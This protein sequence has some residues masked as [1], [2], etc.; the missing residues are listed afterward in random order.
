MNKRLVALASA[1]VLA[2]TAAGA[3]S[4]VNNIGATATT[5]SP[6]GA[7]QVVTVAAKAMPTAT[8]PVAAAPAVAGA[9]TTTR[10]EVLA[11]DKL[12]PLNLSTMRLWNWSGV[13]HASEWDNTESPIPWRFNHVKQPAKADTVFTLDASGA[14]QL[15]AQGGT[16][17]A[18]S[19]IWESEVTL[20][21]LRDGLIVAPLWL[22]D[23]TSRDE[24]DFEFAGRKGLDVT[25]HA[26]VNGVH[27]Q[28]TARLF[29]GRDLSGQ[30]KRFGIKVDQTAGFIEMYVDG[31]RV[32]SWSR[33][34]MGFFV[35]KPMKPL[36]E[37]WAAKPTNANYVQ[38]AGKWTGITAPATVAMT[39]HGYRYTALR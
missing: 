11:A 2:I 39:V 18:T 6:A 3:Q 5:T 36:I 17:A 1:G 9:A 14:P 7:V 10:A 34:G 23:A 4:I 20:P 30:R 16:P 27:K 35:S 38:W 32:H 8:S 28:N 15:Q 22:Y 26:Y 12:P 21:V 13:W 25:L 31:E 33:S 24:I 19:G 37:M 29:A